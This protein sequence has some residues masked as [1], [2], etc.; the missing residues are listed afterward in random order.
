[1]WNASSELDVYIFLLLKAKLFSL[2]EKG[3]WTKASWGL[4][5]IL[6]VLIPIVPNTA[7]EYRAKAL[8]GLRLDSIQNHPLPQAK[9]YLWGTHRT[10][11]NCRWDLT[12]W[13]HWENY[14]RHLHILG[15]Y[16]QRLCCKTPCAGLIDA[17][18]CSERVVRSIALT[19][20]TH[21]RFELQWCILG[22]LC[23][24][25]CTWKFKSVQCY[26]LAFW[27]WRRQH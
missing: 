15:T 4:E 13:G 27:R 17:H 22:I 25:V 7:P 14:H 18:R 12:K 19:V 11:G 6:F 2:W 1:M 3:H 23:S 16:H 21:T 5:Y 8:G 26:Q 24:C 20:E 9:K 10:S